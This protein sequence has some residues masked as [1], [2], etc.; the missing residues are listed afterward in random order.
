MDLPRVEK[1]KIMGKESNQYRD[2]LAD[3]LKEIRN[4]DPENPEIAKAKAGGYLEASKQSEEHKRAEED[5]R[6][7]MEHQREIEKRKQELIQG[8]EEQNEKLNNLKNDPVI[9][10]IFEGREIGI[11]NPK[12]GT[13][14]V[15]RYGEKDHYIDGY[16]KISTKSKGWNGYSEEID[17]EFKQEKERARSAIQL[18]L[19]NQ[20]RIPRSLLNGREYILYDVGQD[21]FGIRWNGGEWKGVEACSGGGMSSLRFKEEINPIKNAIDKINHLR[22]VSFKWRNKNARREIGV[23]AEEVYSVFPELVALDE[24]NKPLSV[25]YDKFVAVLIEAV[26]ELSQEIEKL[27]S[28]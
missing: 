18:L 26:K 3:K 17:R 9:G 8:L 23:I 16:Y 2:E 1:F 25:Y 12:Y 10:F 6:T 7:S 15:V 19:D 4:S 27:K 5:Y 24:N 21:G 11:V 22:G 14:N 13:G 20:D 28:K